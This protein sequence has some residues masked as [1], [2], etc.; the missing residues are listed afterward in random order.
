MHGN[1]SNGAKADGRRSQDARL[2]LAVGFL[3]ALMAFPPR[4]P[5]TQ[6]GGVLFTFLNKSQIDAALVGKALFTD[7][8]MQC[9]SASTSPAPS[10]SPFRFLMARGAFF[11]ATAPGHAAPGS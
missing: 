8:H 3:K 5:P 7:A 9:R 2:R 10:S 11:A 6:R 1:T 4:Q